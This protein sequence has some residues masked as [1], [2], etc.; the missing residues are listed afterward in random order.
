MLQILDNLAEVTEQMNATVRE[1]RAGVIETINNIN[2]ITGDPGP[3]LK[4]ILVRNVEQVTRDI[5]TMT[6]ARRGAPPER[7]AWE[8]ERRPAAR[9]RA[10]SRR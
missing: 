10:S 2:Q 6:A 3:R 1:N 7:A 8:F 4:E 9:P 5:R